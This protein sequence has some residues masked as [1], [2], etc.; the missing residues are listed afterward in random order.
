MCYNFTRFAHSNWTFSFLDHPIQKIIFLSP[1]SD[2]SLNLV[3]LLLLFNLQ[4]KNTRT[5]LWFICFLDYYFFLLLSFVFHW[6]VLSL[7]L[8]VFSLFQSSLRYIG[9]SH[10]S[11]VGQMGSEKAPGRDGLPADFYEFFWRCLSV[12]LL[13]MLYEGC[14]TGLFFFFPVVTW[15]SLHKQV[16]SGNRRPVALVCIKCKLLP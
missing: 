1:W 12:H 9:F 3:L 16:D 13:D 15:F 8:F 4:I 7:F 11:A 5:S 14:K 6:N 2:F 10:H